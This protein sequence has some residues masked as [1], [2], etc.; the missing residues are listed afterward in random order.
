M[1]N[2]DPEIFIEGHRKIKRKI[3]RVFFLFLFQF[4]ST[5]KKSIFFYKHLH[6]KSP[7]IIRE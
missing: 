7:I 1:S 6:L 5:K 4:L 3:I 2:A